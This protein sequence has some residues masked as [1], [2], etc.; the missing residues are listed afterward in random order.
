[1]TG[2]L[3]AAAPIAALT[4]LVTTV[5][6]AQATTFCVPVNHFGCPPGATIQ[7]NLETAANNVATASDGIP[8]V[9][10]LQPGTTY[11]DSN[12]LTVPTGTDPLLI[13]GGSTTTKITSSATDTRSVVDLTAG[14]SLRP[15]TLARVTIEIPATIGPDSSGV[16]L[17]DDALEAVNFATD[18]PGMTGVGNIAGGATIDGGSYYSNLGGATSPGALSAAIIIGNSATGTVDISG[19]DIAAAYGISTSSPSANVAVD[20][21]TIETGQGGL[22]AGPGSIDLSNSLLEA[23][24]GFGL[25]SAV[26][27]NSPQD[28]TINA[29]GV[30]LAG[31]NTGSALAAYTGPFSSGDAD[32]TIRSSIVAG[33]SSPL[34][35]QGYGNG[36]ANISVDYSNFPASPPLGEGSGHVTRDHSISADPQFKNPG[37]GDYTLP[38][39]SPSIDKGDPASTLTTDLAGNPRPIDGDFNGT[40]R[41]DQGAY[42]APLGTDIYPPDTFITSGPPEVIFDGTATYAFS[43]TPGDTASLSCRIDGGPWQGCTSPKTYSNL[44]IG[45]HT[46][47]F[48]AEDAVGN[49]DPTPA[50]DLVYSN[51]PLETTITSGPADG[52]NIASRTATFGFTGTPELLATVECRLDGGPFAACTSPKTFDE[53]GEGPHTVAF[54]AVNAFF[55]AA[56]L[57]PAT[58]TFTVDTTNP[59]T[60]V[61]SGPGKKAKKGKPS[62]AFR[63]DEAA[64]SFACSLGRSGNSPAFTPCTSPQ[65]FKLKQKK[66]PQTFIFSVRAEDPAGNVDTSPTTTVFKVAKK[67][68]KKK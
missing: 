34:S 16:V 9:I 14:G 28:A 12:S 66:K 65:K 40:A 56:D 42:E 60:I 26:G 13:E 62:F 2:K 6:A 33:F 48:R 37:A 53:L 43:G 61:T 52:S 27:D 1:M 58:R 64:A 67:K 10:Y 30:T 68:A 63:S 49:Q 18:A 24:G 45:Y 39:T 21:S 55:G 46:V 11:T 29:D 5:T 51:E 22:T 19:V 44:S 3:F 32:V 15:V 23:R 4:M 7:P 17:K 41:V 20:R 36:Q 47:E 31:A 25:A 54:R 35:R 8:D 38:Q 59:E 57:T 50:S